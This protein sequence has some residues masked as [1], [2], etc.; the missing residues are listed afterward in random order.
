M[1]TVRRGADPPRSQGKQSIVL[2]LRLLAGGSGHGGA[3]RAFSW[4]ARQA[5]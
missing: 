5:G 2:L 4:G 3:P 1:G